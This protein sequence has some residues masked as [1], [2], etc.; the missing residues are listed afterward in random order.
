MLKYIAAL[1]IIASSLL[2]SDGYYYKN[3]FIELKDIP[4]IQEQSVG[5]D[6]VK[7]Y[8][9]VKDGKTLK[10]GVA[11]TILVQFKDKSVNAETLSAKYN[12]KYVKSLRNIH[13]YNTSTPE[14]ALSLAKTISENENVVYAQPSFTNSIETHVIKTNDMPRPQIEL[15][16]ILNS[17]I[18]AYANED[19]TSAT[20]ATGAINYYKY[21]DEIFT[22][23]DFAWW[24]FHNRGGFTAKYYNNG[25]FADLPAVADI[26]TN[27]LQVWEKGITGKGVTVGVIDSGFDM[28][29]ADLKFQDTFS[30]FRENKDVTPTNPADSMVYHG[31]AVAGVITSGQNNNYATRGV[32]PG[33][34]LVA[35]SGLFDVADTQLGTKYIEAM[36]KADDLGVDVLNCSWGTTGVMDNAIEGVLSE[37]A[38]TGRNGKG[39]ILV[40]SSGNDNTDLATSE[41]ALGY[42]LSVGSIEANGKRAQYS[43]YGS[44]LD[45]VAPTHFVALDNTGTTV[46]QTGVDYMGFIAGTSFSSPVVAGVAALMLQVNPGLTRTQV[47]DILYSTAKKVGAGALKDSSFSY[48]YSLNL[49]NDG[50]NNKYTKNYDVGYGLVDAD[51]AIMAA[52]YTTPGSPTT[53][54]TP[55]TTAYDLK[56][57]DIDALATNQWSLI[58]NTTLTTDMSILSGVNIAWYYENSTSTWKAYSPVTAYAQEIAGLGIGF[59]S[60]PAGVGLWVNK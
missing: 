54:T 37:L 47:F 7:Y 27:V 44:A 19:I 58:A 36:Y 42:V 48:T 49:V 41:T 14:E 23:T 57:S 33:A 56:K 6:I 22:Y 39:M 29:H 17:G 3:K 38:T 11:N 46:G 13:I 12:I 8:S 32:A 34:N 28:H 2:A 52:G 18:T 5:D 24:V 21:Y 31:T 25:S 59:T 4:S 16:S 15:N 60:I 55:G 30:V 20:N 43:N 40:F 35:I 26:D 51:A 10:I 9:V 1:S 45:I 53:C 50:F